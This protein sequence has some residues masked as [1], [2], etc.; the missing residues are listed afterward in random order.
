MAHNDEAEGYGGGGTCDSRWPRTLN[1]DPASELTRSRF[2]VSPDTRLPSGWK[3]SAGGYPVPP[4]PTGKGLAQLIEARSQDLS[5][6]DRADLSFEPAS[7]LWKIILNDERRARIKAYEGPVRPSQHNK[8]G[9]QAW[10]DGRDYDKVMARLPPLPKRAVYT[11]M[12]A[13]KPSGSSSSSRLAT[14]RRSMPRISFRASKEEPPSPSHRNSSFRPSKKPNP[15]HGARV[16]MESG[17]IKLEPDIIK[18]KLDTIKP[19]P[20]FAIAGAVAR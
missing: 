20:T 8:R 3:I 6:S 14:S 17:T 11:M 7:V 4:L 13:P 19:E 15:V 18:L 2:L 1:K 9:R 5:E 10:W 16:K 12:A